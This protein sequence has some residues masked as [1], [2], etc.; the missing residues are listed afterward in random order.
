MVLSS[1]HPRRCFPPSMLSHGP[2]CSHF[3]H[4]SPEALSSR[5][6]CSA[7][8]N[9]VTPWTGLPGS[10]VHGILQQE[11]WRGLQFPSPGDLPNPRIIPMSPAS[12]ALQVDSSPLHNLGINDTH[13]PSFFG[14]PSHLRSP[15]SID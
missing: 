11:Y 14:F 3:Q 1:F 12:P 13:I 8:S 4:Q 9:S 6:L 15:Q 7:I 10:S 5:V 2:I